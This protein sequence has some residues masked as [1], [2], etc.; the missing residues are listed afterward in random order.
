M[1][2]H[3]RGTVALMVNGLYIDV[4]PLAVTYAH[5]GVGRVQ[6][7]FTV[8]ESKEVAEL[9]AALVAVRSD[10]DRRQPTVDLN[11]EHDDG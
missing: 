4:A 7:T 8:P 9:L 1:T 3:K 6:F 10:V 11:E 2:E 5:H